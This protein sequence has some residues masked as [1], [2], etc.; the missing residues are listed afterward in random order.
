LKY[1]KNEEENEVSEKQ[2]ENQEKKAAYRP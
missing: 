2:E 1:A